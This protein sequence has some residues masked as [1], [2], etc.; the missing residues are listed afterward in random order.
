MLQIGKVTEQL[1]ISADTLRYYEKINLLPRVYRNTAGV[2]QYSDKD[3]SRLSFIKRAQKWALA[4]RR[5][6]RSSISGKILKQ[7]DHRCAH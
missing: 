2:R 5:S 7:P 4:W 3:L 6:Q 1:D